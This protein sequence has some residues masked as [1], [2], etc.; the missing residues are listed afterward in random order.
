MVYGN[1]VIIIIIITIII[2]TIIK[3]WIKT[4]KPHV[5]N[6][7]ISPTKAAEIATASSEFISPTASGGVK[8]KFDF[9]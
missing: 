6:S 8:R 4:D 7:Y 3:E 2:N 9:K 5:P 1:I